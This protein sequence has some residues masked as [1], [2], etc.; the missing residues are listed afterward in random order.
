MQLMALMHA[1]DTW[2]LVDECWKA[3]LLPVG[4]VVVFKNR[5]YF[6]IE[7]LHVAALAWP[8]SEDLSE[9]PYLFWKLGVPKLEWL[10]CFEFEEYQVQ[11]TRPASPLHRRAT[12]GSAAPASVALLAE[13]PPRPL[14]EWQAARAFAGV[15]EAC[16]KKVHEELGLGGAAGSEPEPAVEQAIVL[17]LMRHFDKD[18]TPE[19]AM[20]ACSKRQDSDEAND[21]NIAELNLDVLRDV[22]LPGDHAE[23]RKAAETKAEAILRRRARNKQSCDAVAAHF[24]KKPMSTAAR[25]KCKK[26]RPQKSVKPGTSKARWRNFAEGDS[27]D[28]ITQ[29]APDEMKLVQ[30]NPNGRYLCAYPGLG[31]KSFS[32]TRRGQAKTAIQ[33]V[34]FGWECHFQVTGEACPIPTEFLEEE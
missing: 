5:P 26:Q 7:A 24:N 2:H 32:W 27:L 11:P 15:P 12:H 9:K 25:A 22:V 34:K 18:L 1:N 31:R 8:V 29:W 21:I 16:V 14:L 13:G 19:E 4:H 10:F 20:R 17:D 23:I 6:I 3:A 33:C 28:F 30:D